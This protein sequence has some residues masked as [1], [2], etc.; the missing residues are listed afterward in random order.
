MII[1]ELSYLQFRDPDDLGLDELD[2][3]LGRL[4]L[5]KEL[6]V[7]R[8]QQ[9][10]LVRTQLLIYKKAEIALIL[11]IPKIIAKSG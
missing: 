7:L 8:L 10:H 9:P 3:V 6:R 1:T 11:R 5:G 2:A 4:E